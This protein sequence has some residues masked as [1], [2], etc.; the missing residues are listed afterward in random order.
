MGIG[1]QG[2]SGSSDKARLGIPSCGPGARARRMFRA[3]GGR[4]EER[5]GEVRGDTDARDWATREGERARLGLADGAGWADV[6]QRRPMEAGGTTD[7]DGRWAV[8]PR[9][10]EGEEG[11]AEGKERG[12][13]LRLLFPNLLLFSFSS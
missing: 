5:R 6:D 4:G 13:G 2:G 10:K 12:N 8:G 11:R 9:G 1:T 7:V 3:A